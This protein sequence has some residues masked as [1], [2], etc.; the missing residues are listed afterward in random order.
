MTSKRLRVVY[1]DDDRG[2][3]EI[4]SEII[5]ECDVDLTT[6]DN[7]KD[8]LCEIEKSPSSYDVI[9]SDYR[10][11]EING[12]FFL[13]ML[14]D[15]GLSKGKE[16]GIFSSLVTDESF[17][18][19]FRLH[20]PVDSQISLIYGK[21]EVNHLINFLEMAKEKLLSGTDCSAKVL[22]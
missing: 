11:P 14:K 20:F 22:I 18:S 3:L 9:I 10:M 4:F 2:L 12:I 5:E 1:V 17:L 8:A 6:F 7:A 13:K 19:S 21:P 15:R 16:L